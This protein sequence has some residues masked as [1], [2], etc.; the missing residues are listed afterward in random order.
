MIEMESPSYNTDSS[1]KAIFREA[2]LQPNLSDAFTQSDLPMLSLDKK[3]RVDAATQIELADILPGNV[4]VNAEVQSGYNRYHARGSIISCP[5]PLVRSVLSFVP[6]MQPIIRNPYGEFSGYYELPRLSTTTLP[7][8]PPQQSFADEYNSK[9]NAKPRI[10]FRSGSSKERRNVSKHIIRHVLKDLGM[11]SPDQIAELIQDPVGSPRYCEVQS[12]LDR[13]KLLEVD[14]LTTNSKVYSKIIY[15]MIMDDALTPV[16]YRVITIKLQ[17]FAEGNHGRIS[18]ENV[19]I[20]KDALLDYKAYIDGPKH[21]K[22]E[23][24]LG[25]NEG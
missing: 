3:T 5:T 8:P 20:Y 16:L 2:A 13:L 25:E 12:F 17:E 6:P 21:I 18:A 14:R 19:A 11:L 15:L 10:K 22:T 1:L 7:T 4:Y 24:T 23:E 9:S